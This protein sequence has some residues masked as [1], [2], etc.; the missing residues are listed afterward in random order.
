PT[1][2]ATG[3]MA[4]LAIT[5]ERLKAASVATLAGLGVVFITASVGFTGLN[6]IDELTARA[7][8]AQREQAAAQ[9]TLNPLWKLADGEPLGH[10]AI[11]NPY[12]RPLFGPDAERQCLETCQA[13]PNMAAE[14]CKIGCSRVRFEEYARRITMFD[15]DPIADA[16]SLASSCQ[17]AHWADRSALTGESWRAAFSDALHLFEELPT[18]LKRVSYEQAHRR[19][20]QLSR[21]HRS[22]PVPADATGKRAALGELAI[23]SLCLRAHASLAEMGY[24]VTAGG[25]DNFSARYYQDLFRA[26]RQ[27]TVA[28]ELDLFRLARAIESE[29]G[30]SA[31]S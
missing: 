15:A 2:K 16:S 10:E 31:L 24:A 12:L 19:F 25:N 5:V 3:W 13:D 7:E 20:D 21:L 27:A 4:R 8:Q 14:M 30:Q 29:T 11:A 23:R 9:R 22:F 18:E 6:P 1:S 17:N 26:L 28:W